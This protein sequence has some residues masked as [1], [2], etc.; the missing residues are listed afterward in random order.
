VTRPLA[1]S[2]EGVI[3]SV[4]EGLQEGRGEERVS[5]CSGGG[6]ERDVIGEEE[7][8]ESAEVCEDSSMVR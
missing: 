1:G 2:V 6:E 3:D 7:R 4:A 8:R 5:S